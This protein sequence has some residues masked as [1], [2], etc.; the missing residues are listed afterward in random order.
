VLKVPLKGT[1]GK[2]RWRIK[3]KSL[4]DAQAKTVEAVVDLITVDLNAGARGSGEV[5][6][7]GGRRPPVGRFQSCKVIKVVD[8]LDDLDSETSERALI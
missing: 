5:R 6:L 7:I 8:R 3:E 2:Y 4:I 1:G